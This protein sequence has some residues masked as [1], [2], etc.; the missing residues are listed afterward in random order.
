MVRDP[1]SDFLSKL[2]N[3]G[4]AGV[5][6]VTVPHSK[7][8]LAVAELLMKEGF[9]MGI[10]K[11]GKKAKRFLEVAVAYTGTGTENPRI[12]GIRRVSKPSRRIYEKAA[13]LRPVRNG[14]G[15]LVLSTPRGLMT[16]VSARKEKV[17]GEVLF[18]IW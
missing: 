11:K 15:R 9:V 4:S 2:S 6:S 14:F 17:G 16:D 18:K 13:R 8:I 10:E 7:L 5:A 1:I 3:A 12:S